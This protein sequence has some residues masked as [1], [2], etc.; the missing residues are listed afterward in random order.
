M[1]LFSRFTRY[2][3]LCD[4][5]IEQLTDTQLRIEDE[6]G[7][8]ALP[9]QP[10][11]HPV[12]QRGF[13]RAHFARQQDEAL[14]VLNSI[15]QPCQRFLNLPRQEEIARIRIDIEWAFTQPKEFLVHNLLRISLC[16]PSLRR[17]LLIQGSR[18]PMAAVPKS[19]QSR[20]SLRAPG[21]G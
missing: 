21:D 12:E 14:A 2:F 8:H 1:A 17:L 10:V 15:R 18:F 4:N 5:E 11:Q 7:G 6:R 13:A 20:E 16:R 19:A 9:V 3:K